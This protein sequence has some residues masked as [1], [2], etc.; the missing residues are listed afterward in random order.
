MRFITMQSPR[1]LTMVLASLAVFSGCSS[2]DNPNPRST[3][4]RPP[5]A[6]PANPLLGAPLVSDFRDVC[7]T[8]AT[9]LVESS[10]IQ[11]AERP[12]VIEIKPV[13]NATGLSMDC[14]IYPETIRAKIIQSAC[15]KIA[16]RDEN[17]AT[18]I[19]QERASQMDSEYTVSE[20]SDSTTLQTKKREGP[21]G[22]GQLLRD[23]PAPGTETQFTTNRLNLSRT[24]SVSGKRAALDYF[25]NGK[26][27]AQEEREA[28]GGR[29]GLKYYQFQFR[30]T[31]AQTGI[32]A[33][34]REYPVKRSGVLQQQETR[35]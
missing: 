19:V 11:T 2:L 8:M 35:P 32:I 30:L 34:E 3:N 21:V 29:A 33:W 16:F 25:L 27:Y 14:K 4:R 22:P 24:G 28:G 9:D 17:S 18:Q 31:H 7:H 26:I 5:E 15:P 1:A 13:D 6:E 20:Q 10:L 12:L 23:T